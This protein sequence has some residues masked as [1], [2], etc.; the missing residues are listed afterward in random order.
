MFEMPAII[1][2]IKMLVLKTQK[3]NLCKKKFTGTF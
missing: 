1:Y 2:V 3:T